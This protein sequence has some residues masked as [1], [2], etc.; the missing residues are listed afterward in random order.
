MPPLPLRMTDLDTERT[1]ERKRTCCE[2]DAEM[3]E[4][5]GHISR[6]SER[7]FHCSRFQFEVIVEALDRHEVAFDLDMAAQCHRQRRGKKDGH[8][9]AEIG[10]TVEAHAFEDRLQR[11]RITGGDGNGH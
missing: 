11:I 2:R 8:I 4:I 5:G 10:G 3:A 6:G 9:I 7:Q 1:T